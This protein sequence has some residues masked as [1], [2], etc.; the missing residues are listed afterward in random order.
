MIIN[1][2]MLIL[3]NTCNICRRCL[4]RV[5][6][7]TIVFVAC[8]E[9][10]DPCTPHVFEQ[11][12]TKQSI[13]ATENILEDNGRWTRGLPSELNISQN[14]AYPLNDFAPLI[15]RVVR[16]VQVLGAGLGFPVG[17]SAALRFSPPTSDSPCSGQVLETG[18]EWQ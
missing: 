9:H 16:A 6:H 3:C 4:E 13:M 17:A 18:I 10:W 1:T 2:K 8:L 5:F 15:C 11:I 14:S 12:L 7:K